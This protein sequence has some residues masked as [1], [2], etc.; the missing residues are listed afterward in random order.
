MILRTAILFSDQFLKD[1]NFARSPSEPKV[2]YYSTF[3]KT[4][5]KSIK[6]KHPIC[7]CLLDQMN[8]DEQ[9]SNDAKKKMKSITALKEKENN[10]YSSRQ[11]KVKR[12]PK[13]PEK[14]ELLY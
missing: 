4:S 2:F 14:F 9:F 3:L 11:L 5:A 1:K 13:S 12:K 7:E 10:T 6:S 8:H